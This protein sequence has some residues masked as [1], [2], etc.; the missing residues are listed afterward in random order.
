MFKI[1]PDANWSNG[2]P[3]TAQHFVDGLRRLV[4]P[5]VAAFYA[6]TISDI[7]N[8]EAIIANAEP[9]ESLGADALGEKALQIRLTRPVPYLLSLLTHPSTFP[10]YEAPIEAVEGEADR[11]FNGAYKLV[12]WQPG[13]VLRLQRNEHYWNNEQTAIDEVH[14]HVITEETAELNRYRA[15]ELHATSTIPPENFDATREEYGGQMHIAPY[16]GVYYYGFNLTRPPFAD[17]PALRQALSMAI[18]RTVLVE[19]ITGRGEVPAYSFVPPGTDNYDPPQH[20]YAELTQNERIAI[21]R[22]LYSEA[23]YSADNPAEIEVRYNTSATQQRIAL[24]IQS[25]WRDALGVEAT[26]IGEEFRVLLTNIADGQNTEAFRGSWIGDYNDATTFLNLLTGGN[27]A[28]L[29]GYI[30]EEYDSLMER[31]ETQVNLDR[32]RLYL[33]EAERVLL[34]DHPVVPLFFYVSKHLV[35]PE[36]QGWEDNVLDY[37]YSQHLSLDAGP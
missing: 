27:P 7:T 5:S 33:E 35:R 28:N 20:S 10:V 3:V 8:A 26:L 12:T 17:N 1:R 22:S 24:A 9:V 30:N 19:K 21:A 34:S 25:M 32:R 15:G 14:H 31:A 29:S 36:V 23:G 16:L 4:D 6:N 18:D 11:Q 2:D 37:H 13:S